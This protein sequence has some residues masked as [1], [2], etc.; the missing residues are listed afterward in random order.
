MSSRVNN[1]AR[2]GQRRISYRTVAG[3]HLVKRLLVASR[4]KCVSVSKLGVDRTGSGSRE[5][6]VFVRKGAE[7]RL[8]LGD[9]ELLTARGV[10]RMEALNMRCFQTKY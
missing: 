10:T 3:K 8:L 2:R 1:E 7:P 4:R 6:P 9:M 5:I